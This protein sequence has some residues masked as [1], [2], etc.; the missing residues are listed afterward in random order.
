MPAPLI[1]EEL[2]YIIIDSLNISRNRRDRFTIREK[3][4]ASHFCL[5]NHLVQILYLLVGLSW[6][7]K[8]KPLLIPCPNPSFFCTVLMPCRALEAFRL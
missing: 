2:Y 4:Q 6:G 3:I 5:L 8:A 1:S 7:E